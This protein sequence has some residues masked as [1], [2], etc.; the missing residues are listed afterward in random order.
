MEKLKSIDN[1]LKF[2][3]DGSVLMIGGFLGVGAPDTLIDGLIDKD[4]KDLTLIVNDTAF[5][6]KS[7]G[8]L[9]SNKQVSKVYTSHIGTNKET[10][11]QMNASEIDVNLIPQGTLIEQIR[12]QGAGL[13]GVLT[14]TGIGTMVE[15]GKETIEIQGEKYIIELPLKA[16]FALVKA[17]KSDESGNLIYDKS[18]RNFNPIIAMAADQVIVETDEI[19]KIGDID[20]NNVD[21]PHIFVDYIVKG[22]ADG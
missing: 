14:P 12:A 10:G 21:T 3:K 15:D 6:N 16:D 20:P 17:Y 19:V 9:I 8:K 13:G 22:G 1:V 7:Y 18:A 4:V 5:E 11:K 2:I